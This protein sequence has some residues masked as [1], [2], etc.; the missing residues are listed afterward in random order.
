MHRRRTFRRE[1]IGHFSENF[2][3]RT[4]RSDKDVSGDTASPLIIVIFPVNGARSWYRD[5]LIWKLADE[6]QLHAVQTQTIAAGQSSAA[7]KLHRLRLS[8]ELCAT[9]GRRCAGAPG[10]RETSAAAAPATLF[11]H[12]P[13][14]SLSGIN[15]LFERAPTTWWNRVYWWET[16][17]SR[18]SSME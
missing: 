5:A 8:L 9:G 16:L 7:S 15:P 10:R 11:H 4:N 17:Q 12:L 1:I 14:E 6:L 18:G 2:G 3:N 13:W